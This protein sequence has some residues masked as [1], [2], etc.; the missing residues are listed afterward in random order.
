MPQARAL[1]YGLDL[2]RE[3]GISKNLSGEYRGCCSVHL[4][5]FCW[6]RDRDAASVIARLTPTNAQVKRDSYLPQG[7]QGL[8][9]VT[10]Y[11]LGYDP[12]EID[13]EDMVR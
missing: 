8:K 13:A 12:V 11:K 9:A 1:V 2:A 10:R 3:T 4:D 7:A 5:A 6:V